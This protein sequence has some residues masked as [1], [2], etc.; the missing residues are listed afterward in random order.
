MRRVSLV[1]LTIAGASTVQGALAQDA[2]VV[3]ESTLT[4]T[5]SQ[6]IEADSN[7]NLDPDS[8][9]TTYLGDT[10]VG[11][12]LVQASETQNLAFTLDTGLRA[13]Q[14]PE[15]DFEFVLASPSSAR[16]AFDQEFANNA[17]DIDVSARSRRID[18][19]IFDPE[20][21]LDPD[22]P[23]L[24]D[25][26]D[27]LPDDVTLITNNTY[28]QRYDLDTGFVTGTASASSLGF[29][30]RASSVDYSGDSPDD[31][32]P[33]TAVE[34]GVAWQLRL[35]PVWSGAVTA[36]YSQEDAD[37]DADTKIAVTEAD[38]GLVYEPREEL[39]V[40]GGIGYA[41]REE[42]QTIAG[43]RS[44]TEDNAGIA[45]RA[46]ANYATEDLAFALNARY[47]T[48]APNPRFSGDFRIGYRGLRSEISARVFQDYGLGSEGDDRRLIGAG[49][50]YGY[51]F[52]SISDFL[53]DFRISDSARADDGDD[54]DG[55]GDADDPDRTQLDF[56]AQYNHAFTPVITGSVGYQLTQRY[57]DPGDATSHRV[58]LQIG[59]SFVTGF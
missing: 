35:N 1:A 30:L 17:F 47:T 57:E 14:E 33:R 6:S 40:A 59:R 45:L 39:S 11:L 54:D 46:L 22:L 28:E 41:V 8:P 10:R 58:F 19:E 15:E 23:P 38:V 18:R 29:R 36:G 27:A 48:A 43:E 26:P 49:V 53:L 16:F 3:A 56:T 50:G 24:P 25:D 20:A 2:P 7:Y 51:T 42:E 13:L 44:T 52:N 37:D 5:I 55:G 12:G 4:A 31:F 21:L 32:V 9:G 34:G